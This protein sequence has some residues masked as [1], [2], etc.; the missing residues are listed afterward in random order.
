[1]GRYIYT[2]TLVKGCKNQIRNKKRE[3]KHLDDKIYK[4]RD[5]LKNLVK[6][7]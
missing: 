7:F 1:M 3:L 6:N 5:M 4:Y 2:C